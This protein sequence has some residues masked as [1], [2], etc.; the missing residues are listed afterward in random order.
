MLKP[1]LPDKLNPDLIFNQLDPQVQQWIKRVVVLP[2]VS[3]TN[4]YLIENPRLYL[5]IAEKQHAGRGQKGR[6]WYSPQEQNIYLS[7]RWLNQVRQDIT[8]INLLVAE[9]IKKLC[10]ELSI[11][12]LVIKPPNDLMIAGKKAAGILIEATT[13]ADQ[14]NLIIGVGINVWMHSVP[15][16]AI[17]QPWTSLSHEVP[18]GLLNSPKF[19][20][21]WLI[22]RFLNILYY[23]LEVF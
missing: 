19:N 6:V 22:S 11:Q 4:Q 1:V 10:I 7:V 14:V 8:P 16:Q 15:D 18:K 21:N 23:E 9:A 20:R 2:E 13:Q 3:S 12:D 5:A 17:D